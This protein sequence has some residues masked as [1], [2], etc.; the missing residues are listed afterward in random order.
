MPSS[1]FDLLS[2]SQ[3]RQAFEWLL[4]RE[5]WVS[6]VIFPI[7]KLRN[8]QSVVESITGID[9]QAMI[10]SVEI[11]PEDIPVEFTVKPEPFEKKYSGDNHPLNKLA[12]GETL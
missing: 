8:F 3:K 1:N 2:D 7:I 6:C 11:R 12:R 4:N 5:P 10:S 9:G